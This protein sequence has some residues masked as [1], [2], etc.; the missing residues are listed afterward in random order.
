MKIQMT[1]QFK[2]NYTTRLKCVIILFL[3]VD[4]FAFSQVPQLETQLKTAAHDSI[5]CKILNNFIK[6]PII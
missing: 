2:I 3:L 5:R 1:K 6:H 4:T